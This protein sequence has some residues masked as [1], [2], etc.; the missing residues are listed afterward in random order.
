MEDARDAGEHS[1]SGEP[2][3]LEEAVTTG[4]VKSHEEAGG[5]G[6]SVGVAR[7]AGFSTDLLRSDAGRHLPPALLLN[8][9]ARLCGGAPLPRGAPLLAGASP[10]HP[11]P[12]PLPAGARAAPPCVLLPNALPANVALS[13]DPK[14][15]LLLQSRPR[16]TPHQAP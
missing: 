6:E 15:L 11:P 2:P 8:H 1:C 16:L 4:A 9:V 10:H 13:E 14:P 3:D 12:S 7:C 5:A